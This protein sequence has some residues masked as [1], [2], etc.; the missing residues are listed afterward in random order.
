VVGMREAAAGG[1]SS[2]VPPGSRTGREED[3]RVAYL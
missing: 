3:T 2:V 1:R